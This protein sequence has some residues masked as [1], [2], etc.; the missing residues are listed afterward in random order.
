[1]NKSKQTTGK[2][3]APPPGSEADIYERIIRE[4]DLQI[5]DLKKY[6]KEDAD[7][8]RKYFDS[9]MEAERQLT[10][11]R[12]KNLG[13]GPDVDDFRPKRCNS[14]EHFDTCPYQDASTAANLVIMCPILHRSWMMNLDKHE[15]RANEIFDKAQSK[16]MENCQQSIAENFKP[17]NS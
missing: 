6:N 7:N 9:W 16:L 1:M 3:Q 2:K 8:A 17:F 4:K 14:C 10:I 13:I 11:L 15:P 5:Q 12:L